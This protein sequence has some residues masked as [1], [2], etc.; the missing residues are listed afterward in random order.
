MKSLHGKRLLGGYLAIVLAGGALCR[1]SG[2]R[3]VELVQAADTAGQPLSWGMVP[4]MALF[5]LLFA[6]TVFFSSPTNPLFYLAAGYLFGAARGTALAA[7]ATTL[8]SATAFLFF[9]MAVTP[10]AFRRPEV[11]NLFLTLVLLRA[12]PWF[13]S[14][15]VNLFCGAARVRPT[16]F[17]ASTLLGSLP[18][19]GVYALAASRMRGPLDASL[20]R[21]PEIIAAL[22]GLGAVSLAGLLQPLRVVAGYLPALAASV[23]RPADHR[24]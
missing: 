7:L 13:P 11:R 15:L 19:A 1:L 22:A 23:V 8:G 5:I 6:L 18:L 2:H 17:V 16:L 20:L 14:P 3:I 9:R 10:P 21:S 12:S 24:T 4:V